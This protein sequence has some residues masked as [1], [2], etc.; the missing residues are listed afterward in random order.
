MRAAATFLNHDYDVH[1]KMV[2]PLHMKMGAGPLTLPWIYTYRNLTNVRLLL[3]W[4]RKKTPL[5]GDAA[6]A[7]S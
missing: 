5:D 7:A 2:C 3:S 4:G 1:M 6:A